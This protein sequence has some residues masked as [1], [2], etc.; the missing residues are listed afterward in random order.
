MRKE[1]LIVPI[2][3]AVAVIWMVAQLLSSVLFERSLRQALEDLEARGEW[4]DWVKDAAREIR[5]GD[6][7]D[8][9]ADQ[10]ESAVDKMIDKMIDDLFDIDWAAIF[11]GQ[12]AQGGGVGGLGSVLS[13]IGS[14]FSGGVGR[15][16]AGTDH[17]RGGLTWVG[18]EGPELT[19]LPQGAK[20]ASHPRSMAMMAQAAGGGR[21]RAQV[22]N[23]YYLQGAVT[24]DELWRRIDRGD[25]MAS[26]VGASRGAAA[27]V[28]IVDAT[29]AEKQRG[30]RMM[31]G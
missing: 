20:V 2:L 3:A 31:R 1:R 30:D 26:Q 11:Q 19:W 17:W 8:A 5:G 22:N 23:H 29:A 4:R 9:L 28:S 12:G 15:N 14:F 16:A 7:G 24:T 13:A 10:L 25:R 27:A 6:I 18:E 21:A